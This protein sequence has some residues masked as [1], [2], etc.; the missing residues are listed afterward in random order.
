MTGEGRNRPRSPTA[1]LH[2]RHGDNGE[3][4]LQTY[5]LFTVF[6]SFVKAYDNNVVLSRDKMTKL[7]HGVFVEKSVD[8]A[9]ELMQILGT[10]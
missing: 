6:I 9:K 8:N 7:A 3:N 1:A 10:T 2:S 5:K 4:V